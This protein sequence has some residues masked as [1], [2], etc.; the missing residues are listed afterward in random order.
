MKLVKLAAFYLLGVFGIICISVFPEFMIGA[1]LSNPTAYFTNLG[2][3]LIT[4]IQPESWVYD[5]PMSSGEYSLIDTLW[6]PFIYSLQIL[7]GALLLGFSLA[8]LFAFAANFLPQKFL[9]LIKRCLDFLESIPDIVVAALVQTLMIYLFKTYDI[10]LFRVASYMEDKAYALPTITLAILPMISLFKI[11]LLMIEEEFAKDYVI[12]LKSKG[13]RKTAILVMHIL[14]N[15]IPTTFHHT[16]VF[17]WAALSSQF[18]IERIFNVHGISFFILE[19][20]SPMTIAASLILIFTP[21]FLIFQLADLWLHR[22]EEYNA[23]TILKA[24]RIYTPKTFFRN[25]HNSF[26]HF[27]WKKLRPWKYA[28]NILRTLYAYIKNWKITV[29][30]LFFIVLICASMIYSVTTNDHIDQASIVYEK[31]GATIKSTPPHSP[32]EPFLLGSDGQG[33]SM[34]DMLIIGAKYTLFFGLLIA[35]LR[36]FIGL[37]GGVMFAFVFGSKRQ[38]W[39]EKTVDSIHFLPLSLVAYILLRPILTELQ[40]GFAYSLTERIVLEIIIL[41]IL[42]VPLTSVLLGNEIKRVLNYEFI[43]S[44]QVLGGGR[45]HIFRRHVFPH[46]SARMTVLFG[47]QFIQ[48]LIIFM[49]LGIFNLFFGGTNISFGLVQDPPRSISYEW[50]GLLGSTTNAL[51]SGNYWLIGWVLLGFMLSIF[52]M[53]FIIYGVK[54]V[55]QTKEGIVYHFR[56]QKKNR[57][58]HKASSKYEADRNSFQ[59]VYKSGAN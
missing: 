13:I 37:L 42:V 21:F 59:W 33:F 5:V 7:L 1:G 35:L 46:I 15:I 41:T 54:E 2:E 22:A 27:D 50:S 3:F 18:I 30:S 36:V 58:S 31:D 23:E 34:L 9:Q 47:Q 29:G 25:L 43:K 12:F 49:H 17:I 10:E 53:Q 4:F 55:Q 44:A 51:S 39:I 28:A 6:D 32:P 16:K 19:S 48:V 52:A 57:L 56:K 11:L 26:I 8:F 14:R 20:F 40:S 45:W 24:Q 38:K